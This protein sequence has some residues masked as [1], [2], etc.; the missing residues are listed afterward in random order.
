MWTYIFSFNSVLSHHNTVKTVTCFVPVTRN[1]YCYV[2]D[3]VFVAVMVF[4]TLCGSYLALLWFVE[5]NGVV[6]SL[7]NRLY[8]ISVAGAYL[9]RQSW[10]GISCLYT[11]VFNSD[12]S[13][14]GLHTIEVTILANIFG[15]DMLLVP[16]NWM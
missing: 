5:Y 7:S 2:V 3:I 6:V 13:C 4:Y 11:A 10:R 14:V 12:V 9:D 1:Y 15:W 8:V 16:H